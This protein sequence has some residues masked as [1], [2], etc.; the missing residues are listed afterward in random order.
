VGVLFASAGWPSLALPAMVLAAVAMF[1]IPRLNRRTPHATLRV[2][3]R[4][5]RLTGAAF[6]D[7][8]S[9]ELTDLLNVS[10]DTK[11]VQHVE[12]SPGPVPAL[13]FI[14]ATVGPA[15]D[16]ARIELVTADG[17]IYL[18]EHRTSHLD[19]TEW[20]SAIRRFLRKN[21]WVPEDERKPARPRRTR[22]DAQR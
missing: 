21:G 14:N 8:L 19:A 20:L 17:P 15:V 16:T 2:E 11:T 18:T 7:P 10:L 22:R 4:A 13:R 12:E 6:E 9:I 5:L 3:R 1:V